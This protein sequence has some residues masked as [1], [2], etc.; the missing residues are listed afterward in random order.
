MHFCYVANKTDDITLFALMALISGQFIK[1]NALYD[2]YGAF[3]DLDVHI[4][5]FY[6]SGTSCGAP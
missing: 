1:L 5:L 6:I 2:I 3:S 4:T